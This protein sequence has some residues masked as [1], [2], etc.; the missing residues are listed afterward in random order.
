MVEEAENNQ[1]ETLDKVV[2]KFLAAQLQGEDPDLD[3][4]VRQHPGLE[5]QI[6]QKVQNCQRVS[7]LFDSLREVDESEFKHAKDEIDLIGKKLGQFEIR[8]MIGRGGMGVVYNGHDT[9]LDRSVAIKSLPSGLM[10]NANARTRF[11]REAKLLASLSH[12]NIGVIHDIIEQTDGSAYLVLEYVPGQTLAERITEGSL[13]LQEALTI[14]LQIAEAVAAAHEHDVIHRDLKPGNIKITP[15]GI[16]KVLDFGLAKALGGEA[17]AQ[18]STVTQPGRL[19][20]TPAYMSPEQARGKPTDKRSDI[21]SFGCLLYEM[22]TGRIPFEGE[23]VSDTLANIL[24]TE[25]GWQALPQSTPSNIQVLLRRCLEKD[26]RR[27]LRDI[28][29]AAIEISETLNLPATAPPVTIPSISLKPA[30]AAK[31]NSRRIAMMIAA[32]III[33]LSAITLRF[34]LERRT[35]PPSEHIR[36]VVAFEVEVPEDIPMAARGAMAISPMAISPDGTHIAFLGRRGRAKQLYLR[37]LNR[38]EVTPIK[39]T[40]GATTAFFSPDSQWLGYATPT[41]LWKVA[42]GGGQPIPIC[43]VTGVHSAFWAQD[44]T[45]IFGSFQYLALARVKASGGV[46][47][48]V[49]HREGPRELWHL[50]PEVLPG[51]KT[52][53]FGTHDGAG[54]GGFQNIVARS[55]VTGERKTLLEGAGFPRYAASGHLVYESG[56]TM[57]AAP[58]DKDT[59]T[60]TGPAVRIEDVRL[61]RFSRQ[62]TL[63]WVPSVPQP[64][65]M[66]LWVDREGNETPVIDKR[67]QYIGPRVSPDGN[68]LAFWIGGT[69]SHVWTLD[70][71]RG[72]MDQITK[73]GR[74]FWCSWSPD[75]SRIA[76]TSLRSEENA[77]ACN[78]YWK[79]AD[80]SGPTEQLTQGPFIDNPISWTHDGKSIIVQRSYRPQT[81]WDVMLLSLNGDRTLQPLLNSP[82]NESRGELS[83]DGRWLTYVSTEAGAPGI[84]VQAFQGPKRK[85]RISPSG[86]SAGDPLWSPDGRELFYRDLDAEKI[87]AVEIETADEFTPSTP[88]ALFDDCYVGNVAYGRDYDIMPDGQRFVM[89]KEMNPPPQRIAVILNWFEELKR[90]APTNGKQ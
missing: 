7:S 73:T 46:P 65:I 86:I 9:R 38:P 28:G 55:L 54:S 83:P 89:L 48:P 61:A 43:D 45:I 53:I 75:G 1:N 85:W 22:L 67:K 26:P 11:T 15:D 90:L 81:G 35:Q 87:M 3:E 62:G 21:W 71:R 68:H 70:L 18:Q 57:L 29:D 52:V 4:F 32:I 77:E 59:L 56:Q 47:Q 51:G 14:A 66:L 24:Q 17:V 41:R 84:F 27:R 63:A 30:T 31:A 37:P 33:V 72:V 13:K 88:Q 23:T 50:D 58:F 64:E 20:G 78:L 12:P 10:D 16:V 25:P 42:L 5:K 6:R 2:Q 44:N 79:A 36:P 40:D 69:D 39:G 82:A 80:G 60:L 49:S 34:I 74:N 76:F 19:M 8:E